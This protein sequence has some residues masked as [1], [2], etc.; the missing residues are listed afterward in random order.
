[1][2]LV[3]GPRAF[4]FP[5]RAGPTPTWTVTVPNDPGLAGLPVFSQAVHLSGVTPFALSNAVD[6]C[7]GY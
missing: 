5:L 6:L 2:V 7:L 4:R 3:S 1:M